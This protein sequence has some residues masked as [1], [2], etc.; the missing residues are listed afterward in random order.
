[1]DIARVLIGRI[2][3]LKGSSVWDGSICGF[4][5][6]KPSTSSQSYALL[7]WPVVCLFIARKW[8]GVFPSEGCARAPEK[9]VGERVPSRGDPLRAPGGRWGGKLDH[10]YLDAVGE[11]SSLTPIY[12][13][14]RKGAP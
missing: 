10:P 4:C 6:F 11:R 1:M 5:W 14:R 8:A 3:A 12:S 9:S 7:I 2:D 13:D